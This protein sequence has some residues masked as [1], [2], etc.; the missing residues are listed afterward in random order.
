MNPTL[1]AMV[2]A[3]T[4]ERRRAAQIPVD[5]GELE[6]YAYHRLGDQQRNRPRCFFSVPVLVFQPL[7][8]LLDLRLRLG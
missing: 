3:V 8:A 1:S 4:I 5:P 7:L 6:R 2:A